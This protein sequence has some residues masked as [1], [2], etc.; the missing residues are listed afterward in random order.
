MFRQYNAVDVLFISYQLSRVLLFII[1]IIIITFIKNAAGDVD[2]GN[3]NRLGIHLPG[4]RCQRSS[5]FY[6]LE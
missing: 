5:D 3:L 2:F 1:I 6:V 4:P